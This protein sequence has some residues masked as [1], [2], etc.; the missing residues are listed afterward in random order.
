MEMQENLDHPEILGKYTHESKR[1]L[2]FHFIVIHY[3]IFQLTLLLD[4]LLPVF[5]FD[6]PLVVGDAAEFLFKKDFYGKIQSIKIIV[7]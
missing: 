5:L 2:F 7:I 4:L 1:V 3:V 6:F